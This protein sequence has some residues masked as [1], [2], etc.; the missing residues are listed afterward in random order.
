MNDISYEEARA[1]PNP[2]FIDVRAPVEFEED[3]IPGAVNMPLFDN[4]E[5][6]EIGKIYKILGKEDAIVRGSE[7]AGLKI[8]DIAADIRKIQGRDIVI[9]CFRGGMRSTSLVSLLGSLDFHIY[10]LKDGYKGYRRHLLQ[11]IENLKVKPVLFVLHG[12]TGAGKTEIIRNIK[13]SVDLE[14]FA[15]HRSSVFGAMGLKKKTQKMFES[16]LAD[17]LEK[18]DGVPYIVTEGESRKIGDLHIPEKFLNAMFN[19]PGILIEA[20]MERRVNIILNEYSPDLDSDEVKKI[21]NSISGRLGNKNTDL[22]LELFGKGDLRG[23]TELLLKKYYDPL[24]AHTLDKM[25]FIAKIE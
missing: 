9:Y 4:Y 18:L 20:S 16:L 5:R 7:I 1:L 12:L 25:N 11:Q 17:R 2:L 8:G 6:E 19:S 21:V 23:F 22:L 3:H 14:D 15:G 24:Y 13:N 10:R